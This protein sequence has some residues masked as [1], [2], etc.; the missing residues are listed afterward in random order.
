MSDDGPAL[1]EWPPVELIAGLSLE[2]TA[3]P[4]SELDEKVHSGTV[5]PRLRI[6]LCS[7]VHLA[8]LLRVFGR[9]IRSHP[10]SGSFLLIL[11]HH[12]E[13]LPG[14]EVLEITPSG[15][16]AW[17]QTVRIRTRQKDGTTK[18][19]FKKVQRMFYN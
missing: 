1:K 5:S 12:L 18:D 9:A 17:V 4:E 2:T 3:E 11:G 15:A 14:T 16:S 10:S 8:R 6:T 7:I 13:L 19:Y